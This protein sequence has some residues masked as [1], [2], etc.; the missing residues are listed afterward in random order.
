M[1]KINQKCKKACLIYGGD[2]N[3]M[4]KDTWIISYKNIS[5][6]SNLDYRLELT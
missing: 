5:L 4:E 2:E 3:F 1:A 6:L